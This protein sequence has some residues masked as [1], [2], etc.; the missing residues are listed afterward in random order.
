MG[1][2]ATSELLKTFEKE[3]DEIIFGAMKLTSIGLSRKCYQTPYGEV[4]V[5]CHLYQSA[6]SR[7]TFF[8]LEREA[9]IIL[10]LTPRFASQVSYKMAEMPAP[11]V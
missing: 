8:S 5:E 9:R 1:Q 11:Q 10:T 7:A 4:E 3:G 6:L 2:V